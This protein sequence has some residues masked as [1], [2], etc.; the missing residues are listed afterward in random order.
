MDVVI[1]ITKQGSSSAAHWEVGWGHDFIPITPVRIRQQPYQTC[2]AG[3]RSQTFRPERSRAWLL[4]VSPATATLTNPSLLG[5]FQPG[6]GLKPPWTFLRDVHM[7]SLFET[8]ST[9]YGLDFELTIPHSLC[10]A[11]LEASLPFDWQERPK[12]CDTPCLDT[13]GRS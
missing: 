4:L 6:A 9:C 3:L 7:Y 12:G 11:S 10:K 1:F 13:L 2:S 5:F 8:P